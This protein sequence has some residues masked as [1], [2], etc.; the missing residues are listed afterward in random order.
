MTGLSFLNPYGER[1]GEYWKGFLAVLE[2]DCPPED[3]AS[4]EIAASAAV[5]GFTHA[6]AT[7]CVGGPL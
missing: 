7:L 3:P 4:G 1:T 2:R 6:E 5:L